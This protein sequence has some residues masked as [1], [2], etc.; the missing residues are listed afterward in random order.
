VTQFFT[1]KK[2]AEFTG[3]SS[4]SIRRTVLYPIIEDDNH[5][6]R[7]HI[8][9]SVE[10]ALQLRVKGENFAWQLSEELLRREFP[11]EAGGGKGSP[12]SSHKE[13]AHEGGALLA[14]LERELDIKNQQIGQQAELI[15][16]Q[17][18]LNS[19]LSERLREG[20]MLMASLQRQLALPAARENT[21]DATEVKPS[22]KKASEKGSKTQPKAAKPKGIFSRWFK[23]R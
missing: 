7:H 6:D 1:V 11:P 14:M 16:K 13:S 18:E 21:V 22:S 20:N 3:K 19:D 17:M 15:A 10:E 5:P 12:G 23:K 8:Q 4:S 2:A 9:P